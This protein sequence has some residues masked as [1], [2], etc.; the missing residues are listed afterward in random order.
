LHPAPT[1]RELLPG[2]H[3]SSFS[4]RM[5]PCERK[6]ESNLE[7]VHSYVDKANIPTHDRLALQECFSSH[8]CALKHLGTAT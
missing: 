2:R 8:G 6:Q 7:E 1:F 4:I 5:S 3:R